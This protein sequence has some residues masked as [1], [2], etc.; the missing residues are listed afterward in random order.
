LE[1][2]SGIVN[3]YKVSGHLSAIPVQVGTTLIGFE[4]ISFLGYQRL[5]PLLD[6]WD[7]G[8]GRPLFSGEP[9]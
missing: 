9:G 4:W 6:F 2:R 5:L 7:M 1:I 8:L 3:E